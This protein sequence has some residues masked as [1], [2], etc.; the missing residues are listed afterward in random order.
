MELSNI[1]A[2]FLTICIFIFNLFWI[3]MF[4]DIAI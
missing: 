2:L 3:T 4:S 1:I